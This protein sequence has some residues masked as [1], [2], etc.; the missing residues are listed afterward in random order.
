MPEPTE[1]AK[2]IIQSPLGREII[3]ET[4]LEKFGEVDIIYIRVDRNK[5]YWVKGNEYGSVDLW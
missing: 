4:I 1:P 5:A 3:P 2:V